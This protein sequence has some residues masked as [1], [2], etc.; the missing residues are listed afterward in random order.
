[1]KLNKQ[2]LRRR[3]QQAGLTLIE[4]LVV[5]VILTGLGSLLLPTIN[6]ALTRT[7]VATCSATFPEVHSMVQRALFDGGNIG[8]TL[9]SG[10]FTGGG[11]V[12]ASTATGNVIGSGNLSTGEIAALTYVGLNEVVDHAASNT[13]GYDPTFQISGV[14]ATTDEPNPSI[15]E[16]ITTATELIVFN[17]AEANLFG[18]YLPNATAA[19]RFVLLMIGREWSRLGQ[20]APEPPVHFGDTP[21]AL[22]NEVHSRFGMVLQVTDDG[23]A[24]TAAQFITVGYTLDGEG[25]ETRDAHTE[26]YWNEV[27]DS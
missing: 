7:H 4:L 22:P 9:Q 3:A 16:A 2:N 19:D 25:I 5:L 27:V 8:N 24:L 14:N 1:M 13:A 21:G 15:T 11:L 17:G 12:N 23:D 18:L 6:D 26:V 10:V 20:F